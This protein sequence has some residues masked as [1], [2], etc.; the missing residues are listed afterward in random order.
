MWPL[1]SRGAINE[2]GDTSSL[3]LSFFPH[4]DEINTVIRARHL[5]IRFLPG[6]SPTQDPL[7][8]LSA[9]PSIFSL[10]YLSEIKIELPRGF[11]YSVLSALTCHDFLSPPS[12]TF[13]LFF[14]TGGGE[15]R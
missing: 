12:L 4:F 9:G 3:A 5:A 15:D 2:F 14:L 6:E 10:Y 1:Q 11:T 13:Q 8:F 7:F